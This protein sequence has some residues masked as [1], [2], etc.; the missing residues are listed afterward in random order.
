MGW[1]FVLDLHFSHGSGDFVSIPSSWIL[2]T[3]DICIMCFDYS[4]R[5]KSNELTDTIQRFIQGLHLKERERDV[6]WKKKQTD[7]QE[8][9]PGIAHLETEF[10]PFRADCYAVPIPDIP[11]AAGL[12]SG[13]LWLILE[14]HVLHSSNH[15]SEPQARQ[16]TTATTR[17]SFGPDNLHPE[18]ACRNC[19]QMMKETRF[20]CPFLQD[21]S[22]SPWPSH[23]NYPCYLMILCTLSLCPNLSSGTGIRGSWRRHKN[24]HGRSTPV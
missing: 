7:R 21:P 9:G 17:Q 6:E 5:K 18:K 22:S 15:L 10:G 14:Q 23:L 11:E 13:S 4:Q 12:A 8:D 3:P 2:A 24:T 20:I 1:P 16:S 19:I